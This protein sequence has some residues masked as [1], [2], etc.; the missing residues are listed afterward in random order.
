MFLPFK[1]FIVVFIGHFCVMVGYMYT[2]H[3]AVFNVQFNRIQYIK[4][5]CSITFSLST[6]TEALSPLG[7]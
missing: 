4:M 6:Q 5:L 3:L 2:Y 1:K 7:Y